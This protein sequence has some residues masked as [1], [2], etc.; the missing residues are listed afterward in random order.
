[1]YAVVETGGKQYKVTEGATIDVERLSFELGETVELDRVM[2][3]SDGESVRIGKPILD[4][5]AVSATV[6]EHG[7]A[8][9]VVVFK[10]RPKQRYRNKRGHRQEYT[11]LRIDEIKA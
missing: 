5:T 1:M 11:R 6:V 2:M 7:R 10:Y 9:K 3:V 4:D 8:P